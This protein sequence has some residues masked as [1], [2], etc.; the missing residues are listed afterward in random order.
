MNLQS[1][2]HQAKQLQIRAGVNSA[3]ELQKLTAAQHVSHSPARQLL[4]HRV[5]NNVGSVKLFSGTR[6][7]ALER[8][9]PFRSR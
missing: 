7:P 5:S 8:R 1:A 4:K 6:Q 2:A 9:A 3:T